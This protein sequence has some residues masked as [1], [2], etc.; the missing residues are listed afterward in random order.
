MRDGRRD[1]IKDRRTE[2][3]IK[4]RHEGRHEGRKDEWTGV[5]RDQYECVDLE[6]WCRQKII[7]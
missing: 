5:V 2:G 4:G 6:K 3:W 1:G 7:P